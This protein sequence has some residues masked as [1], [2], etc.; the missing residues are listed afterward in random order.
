MR[1]G[2]CLLAQPAAS[3]LC[4]G[5]VAGSGVS[6]SPPDRALAPDWAREGEHRRL[7]CSCLSV[8]LCRVCPPPPTPT[9][10]GQWA[11][12][13]GALRVGSEHRPP[14][15]A[16]LQGGQT[17]F[18]RRALAPPEGPGWDGR[19]AWPEDPEFLS[20]GEEGPWPGGVGDLSW[21]C[22]GPGG[23][24]DCGGLP[25]LPRSPRAPRVGVGVPAKLQ[26]PQSWAG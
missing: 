26:V 13:G 19:T 15:S 23:A 7:A 12:P 3:P 21:G 2:P 6:G 14:L 5:D 16:R 8:P 22:W 9:L 25:T 20:S 4:W 24:T 18:N 10:P 1:A 11:G 17:G